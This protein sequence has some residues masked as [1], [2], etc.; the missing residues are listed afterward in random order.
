MSTPQRSGPIA[1]GV[2]DSA[3]AGLRRW[4]IGLTVLH[5]A[6]AVAILLLGNG[7]AIT[8]NSSFPTG[9]PG[10]A[11]PPPSSLVDVSIGAA[12]A[13]FL[14]LAAADHLLT[15]TVARGIYESDLRRGINRFRWIEYSIS[16]TIMIVLIGFYFGLTDIGTVIVVCGANI[17]MIL[18]GWLQERTNPPGRADTTM[19]PFWFGCV[20]GAAPWVAIVVNFVG[21]GDRVPGFVIGIFVSLLVFFS[22][23][24]INQWLQYR[25][26]GPWRSYAFG[27]KTYLVLSLVAKSLLAWQIFGGSLAV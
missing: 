12:I 18:F 24:A 23:F 19:L 27:E 21:A 9:P 11:Q 25:E 15:A 6:Q 16:A 17:A 4:N 3:L 7:F 10:A 26:I 8:V 14:F 20:A 2:T 13:V 22:T 5:A 1:T